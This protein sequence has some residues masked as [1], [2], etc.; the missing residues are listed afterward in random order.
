[1]PFPFPSHDWVTALKDKLNTSASYAEIAKTWEGDI[2]FQVDM[3]DGRALL[4]YLD[5][6]HGQCRNAFEAKDS[7]Q[8]AA[9][10]LSAPLA[11]FVKVLKG[12]L[13]PMQAMMT[14]RLKV[15]G[16]MVVL[17]KNIPTVLEFVNVARTVETVFPN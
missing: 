12:E 7:S 1:M 5:L 15:Q 17:M 16:S 9:F 2:L 11:N 14:G 4:L 6:W 13:D 3:P 8:Q 10:R